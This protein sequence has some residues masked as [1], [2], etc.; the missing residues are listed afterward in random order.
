MAEYSLAQCQFWR[1]TLRPEHLDVAER[2]A[3][4]GKN[5]GTLRDTQELRGMWLLDQGLWEPAAVSFQEAVGTARRRGITEA[6][7]ETGLALAK[8]YLGR[9]DEPEREAERLAAMRE[10][11]HRYLALLWLA[12]GDAAKA[13][14]HALAAYTWAWA[15]GEPYVRRYAL[16]K[17]KESLREMNVPIPDF[18]SYDPA[19]DELFPL[20]AEVHAAIDKLKAT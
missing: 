11:A 12:L 2:V 20:E 9:L 19:K 5:P 16:A 4:E 14:R 18:P 7:C 15:D 1:G 10:P 8:H 17:A 13:K 6:G 3:A